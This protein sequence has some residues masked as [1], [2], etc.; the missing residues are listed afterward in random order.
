[1]KQ[2]SIYGAYSWEASKD[3]VSTSLLA[4]T[5]GYNSY[6]FGGK[7]SFGKFAL[8][9]GFSKTF[10]GDVTVTKQRATAPTTVTGKFSNNTVDTFY[11]SI[12]YNH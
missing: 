4:I 2:L 3:H 9:G 10:L 6:A 11:A 1:M 12:S 7:F 8:S 5:D